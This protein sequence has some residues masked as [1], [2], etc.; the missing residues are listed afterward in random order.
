MCIFS[1]ESNA[2][3]VFLLFI[4]D[5]NIKVRETLNTKN[6]GDVQKYTFFLLPIYQ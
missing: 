4:I 1:S 3:E 2:R 6:I 5:S